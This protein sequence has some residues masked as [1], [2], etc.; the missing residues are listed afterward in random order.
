M[1][2]CDNITFCPPNSYPI[3]TVRKTIYCVAP[4]SDIF[5]CVVNSAFLRCI[6]TSLCVPCTDVDCNSSFV[7]KDSVQLPCIADLLVFANFSEISVEKSTI[8]MQVNRRNVEEYCIIVI[9][10]PMIYEER[11]NKI[12]VYM[13][14]PTL[15]I[16]YYRHS[17]SDDLRGKGK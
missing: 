17:G 10:D 1:I 16:L 14:G 12:I 15:I 3:C 6:N 8:M 7:N 11:E 13:I 2:S 9:A 5:G 4:V